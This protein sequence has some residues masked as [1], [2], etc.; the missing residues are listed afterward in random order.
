MQQA[1]R[2]GASLFAVR[3]EHL[4]GLCA[5]AVALKVSSCSCSAA[6]EHPQLLSSTRTIQLPRAVWAQQQYAQLHSME[7]AVPSGALCKRTVL[8]GLAVAAAAAVAHRD[9]MLSP[10][11][12]LL[13]SWEQQGR[14]QHPHKQQLPWPL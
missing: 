1:K 8:P 11:T 12:G 3:W 6:H 5:V 13:L 2:V 14:R 10:Q 9:S 7:H 4:P